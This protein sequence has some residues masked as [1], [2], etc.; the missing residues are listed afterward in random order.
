VGVDREKRLKGVPERKKTQSGSEWYAVQGLKVGVAA[1][2]SSKKEKQGETTRP[3][4]LDHCHP[5]IHA[6]VALKR[7][8]HNK[9]EKK[10]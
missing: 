2:S 1:H 4:G 5:G 10:N 7:Q 3:G 9:K 8:H 6:V